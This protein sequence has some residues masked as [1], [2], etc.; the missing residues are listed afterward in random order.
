MQL[1]S[2]AVELGFDLAFADAVPLGNLRHTLH[3]QIPAQENQA[4][5]L[6]EAFQKTLQNSPQLPAVNFRFLPPVQDTA[7]ST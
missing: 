3:I 1:L 7:F 4:A 2:A 5:F 6:T